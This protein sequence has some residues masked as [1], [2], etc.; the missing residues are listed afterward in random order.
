MFFDKYLYLCAGNGSKE[1]QENY[2]ND[3]KTIL[4]N[5]AGFVLCGTV[6]VWVLAGVFRHPDLLCV[7]HWQRSWR[8]QL[9]LT[10]HWPQIGHHHRQPG[11]Q[12]CDA[13]AV[14][15]IRCQYAQEHQAGSDF[16]PFQRAAAV[17]HGC[18]DSVLRHDLRQ[19]HASLFNNGR[20]ELPTHGQC[21]CLH[22][23]RSHCGTTLQSCL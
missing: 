5:D 3:E 13:V 15:G 10:A 12:P 16:Q 8:D 11:G 14:C 6:L 4:P 21:V 20:D 22:F 1:H 2:K 23:G 17:G 19:H 18:S 9:G 7:H